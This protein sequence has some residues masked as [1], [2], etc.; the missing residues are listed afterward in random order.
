MKGSRTPLLFYFA[1][2]AANVAAASALSLVVPGDYHRTTSSKNIYPSRATILLTQHSSLLIGSIDVVPM[3]SSN[4]SMAMMMMLQ[5]A[6]T[7][8]AAT[9]T[10]AA[11]ASP[12]AE[13]TMPQPSSTKKASMRLRDH[14][15]QLKHDSDVIFAIFDVNGRGSISP[16]EFSN[17]LVKRI[18]YGASFVNQLFE[19]MDANHDGTISHTEFRTLYLAVPSLRTLP[20]IGQEES[21]ASVKNS[22]QEQSLVNHDELQLVAEHPVFEA[23]DKD[24]NGSIDVTE[25]ESQPS[26]WRLLEQKTLTFHYTAVAKIFGLLDVN[27]DQS[28]SKR[29]FQD[30]FVRYSTLRHA[31]Q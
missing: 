11:T 16:E 2:A 4:K 30:A 29:E 12:D 26:R 6:T 18:G 8:T 21:L 25:L 19:G 23:A 9:T 28:I 14:D 13:P 20:G 31:L 24:G 10:A 22:E 1:A 15:D 3:S 27:G 17:H 5:N 7:T